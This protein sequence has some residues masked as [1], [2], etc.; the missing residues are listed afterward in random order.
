MHHIWHYYHKGGYVE[1]KLR[2]M[3]KVNTN[4]PEQ[5][6]LRL[7]NSVEKPVRIQCQCE[8]EDCRINIF[9]DTPITKQLQELS[10]YSFLEQFFYNGDNLR[11]S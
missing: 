5:H 10:F 3:K 6:S 1:L 7:K 4:N 8:Q 2:F 11:I 9:P